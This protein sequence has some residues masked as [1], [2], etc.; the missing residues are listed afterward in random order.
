MARRRRARYESWYYHEPGM[1]YALQFYFDK[2][3]TMR[4][5]RALIRDRLKLK[6][7]PNGS[8]VWGAW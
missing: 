7:L 8:A 6:R 5:C 1:V 4:E 3:V 2:P